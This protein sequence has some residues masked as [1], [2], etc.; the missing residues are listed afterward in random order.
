MDERIVAPKKDVP[1]SKTRVRAIVVNPKSPDPAYQVA[2]EEAVNPETVGNHFLVTLDK[3][4][5]KNKEVAAARAGAALSRSLA[6]KM[7]GHLPDSR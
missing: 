4:R 1:A 7:T 3:I 2:I 5:Q 6:V